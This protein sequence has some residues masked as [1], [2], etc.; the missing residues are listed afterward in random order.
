MSDA[1]R[2]QPAWLDGLAPG[3]EVLRAS[4]LAATGGV[5]LLGIAGF[6]ALAVFLSVI[7]NGNLLIAAGFGVAA[8]VLGVM[9]IRQVRLGLGSFPILAYDATGLYLPGA[10]CVRWA[11][12]RRIRPYQGRSSIMIAVDLEPSRKARLSVPAR[13]A[14]M[15]AQGDLRIAGNLLPVSVKKLLDAID[16]HYHRATRR[17]VNA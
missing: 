10:G 8:L 3:G 16:P 12:I 7:R 14:A 17:H 11:D 15:T 13:L 4:K 9:G 5:Y 1:A 2:R 6:A